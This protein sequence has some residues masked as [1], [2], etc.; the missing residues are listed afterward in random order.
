MTVPSLN[1]G[2]IYN[3]IILDKI[4]KNGFA[5]FSWPHTVSRP[6]LSSTSYMW[7][8]HFVSFINKHGR[9][10]IKQNFYFSDK[11]C[12]YADH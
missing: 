4:I 11:K 10:T 5:T 9:S 7:N 8:I 12:Q 1:N 2:Y 6:D 3:I